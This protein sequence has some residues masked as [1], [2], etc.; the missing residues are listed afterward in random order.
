MMSSH[1]LSAID[2]LFALRMDGICLWQ[3]G[4]HTWYSC[5]RLTPA[6]ILSH[7]MFLCSLTTWTMASNQKY[8]NT[9]LV[10]QRFDGF[11]LWQFGADTWNGFFRLISDAI[12]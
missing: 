8:Y 10:K 4:A 12:L 11:C 1:Q 6:A 7:S 5:L 9:C 3:F 2:L